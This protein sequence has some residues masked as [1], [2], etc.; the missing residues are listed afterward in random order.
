MFQMK[1]FH[2]ITRSIADGMDDCVVFLDRQCTITFANAAMQKYC[3][4][5]ERELL[6]RKCH[7]LFKGSEYPC[8]TIDPDVAC[9]HSAVIATGK[10]ISVEH[11]CSFPGKKNNSLKITASPIK[12]ADG[13]VISVMNLL[14]DADETRITE[15][16]LN[17]SRS[18]L[19]SVLEGIGDSL[20][21]INRDFNIVSANNAY[22]KFTDKTIH[23][24]IGSH[25]YRIT[26][27][28]DRPCYSNGK[29]CAVMHTFES[30]NN[31][32]IVRKVRQ[33]NRDR[34]M[35]I[36]AFPIK[37]SAG[38]VIRAVEIACD[39]TEKI[40][41]EEDLKKRVK[42]LEDFYD[43]AVGREMKIVELKS[44]IRRLKN[45]LLQRSPDGEQ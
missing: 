42:E 24:V 23:E 43:M 16:E 20:I 28:Y 17:D 38:R 35:E 8:H 40:Q 41:L 13:N 30:G 33:G 37:N 32:T 29:D 10:S 4:V 26:H 25:C 6:S 18:F 12:D 15:D 11:V 21:V 2:H 3:G 1:D 44:E 5:E 7:S 34:Y 14:K 36:R 31:H 22:L 27:G 9:P 45:E 39:I 19:L